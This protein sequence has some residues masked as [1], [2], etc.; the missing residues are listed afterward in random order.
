MDLSQSDLSFL[1][2]SYSLDQSPEQLRILDQILRSKK[3]ATLD[4]SKTKLKLKAILN[5]RISINRQ[6]RIILPLSGGADSRLLLGIILED[7]RSDDILIVSYGLKETYDFQISQSISQKLNLD[8]YA[9]DLTQVDWEDVLSNYDV[10]LYPV[11]IL[12]KYLNH[13]EYIRSKND[14][15][16][17]GFLGD[18]V[19]GSHFYPKVI[20]FSETDIAKQFFSQE[21]RSNFDFLSENELIEMTKNFTFVSNK[22]LSFWEQIDFTVRQNNYVRNLFPH[23]DKVIAPFE[24][25]EWIE[26]WCNLASKLRFRQRAYFNFILNEFPHLSKFPV[27]N[28]LNQ[29]LSASDMQ[30]MIKKYFMR[31]FRSKSGASL[32]EYKMKNYFSYDIDLPNSI[33]RELE[34]LDIIN[35]RGK[36]AYTLNNLQKLRLYSL[37]RAKGSGQLNAIR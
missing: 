2:F 3:D 22:K 1:N 18:F 31:T 16:I 20:N 5:E 14:Y 13:F 9:L 11:D 23:D 30:V 19:A 15:L 7:Y 21:L 26:I 24:H 34:K 8:N 32:L 27:K 28:K 35:I 37:L 6:G 33:L 4:S 10:G 36:V 17:V 29:N 25:N 12:Q